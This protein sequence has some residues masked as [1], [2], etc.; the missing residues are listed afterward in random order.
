MI[1]QSNAVFLGF[2]AE[3]FNQNIKLRRKSLCLSCLPLNLHAASANRWCFILFGRTETK[4]V[5]YFSLTDIDDCLGVS[6]S[7]NGTCVDMVDGY[8]CSCVEGFTG[9]HCQIGKSFNSFKMN[10]SCVTYNSWLHYFQR[11]FRSDDV[12]MYIQN[13]VMT[14]K[15]MSCR[16]NYHRT[17]LGQDFTSPL[18]PGQDGGA[19]YPQSRAGW[20]TPLFR[21]GWGYPPS[22]T[23]WGIPPF[24]TEW[25]PPL[26]QDWMG[27]PLLGLDRDT[28]PP[29]Q[30]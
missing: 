27:Y 19:G 15:M 26:I 22:R 9:Q 16:P 11:H 7:N 1:Q 24:K 18:V 10:K 17:A 3:I 13:D 23:G 29:I 20:G 28:P 14:C 30:D 6:C 5:F 12:I 25:D 8:T 2:L 4:R 21:T